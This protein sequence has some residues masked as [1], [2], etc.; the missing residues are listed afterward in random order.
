MRRSVL[1]IASVA[2][3]A[4]VIAAH[5]VPKPVARTRGATFQAVLSTLDDPRAVVTRRTGH[6]S[7]RFGTGNTI[8][9]A[10]NE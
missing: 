3:L 2:V 1:V 4:A 10:I 9:L 6:Q 7:E 8:W 5:V